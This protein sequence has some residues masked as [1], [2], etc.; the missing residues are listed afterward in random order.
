M[1]LWDFYRTLPYP[2]PIKDELDE[3]Q[4]QDIK[5]WLSLLVQRFEST[6]AYA[7]QQ[8][9]LPLAAIFASSQPRKKSQDTKPFADNKQTQHHSTANRAPDFEPAAYDEN[10][11]LECDNN[12]QEILIPKNTSYN[13]PDVPESKAQHD[14]K[15]LFGDDKDNIITE[16]DNPQPNK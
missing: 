2:L 6:E 14:A 15:R 7:K 8:L 10:S 5:P 11:T 4:N 3:I 1:S 9:N 12:H 16:A 13:K